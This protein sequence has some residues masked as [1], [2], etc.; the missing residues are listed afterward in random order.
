MT[1]QI[2]SINM[3]IRKQENKRIAILL[4]CLCS[5]LYGYNQKA[6]HVVLISIDGFRPDFY[7]D[8][9][10]SAPNLR[11]MM[12]NGAY[13]KGVR[14]VFPSVTYPAHTTIITGAYPAKHGIYY[15][16]PV[17]SKKGEWYWEES[18]IKV[19]TLWDAVHDAGLRSG[20]VMWPVTVGAP[21][22]YNFPVKRADD[23]GSGNQLEVTLP[24]VKPSTLIDDFQ[25]ETGR[26]TEADFNT[27]NTID[28]TIGNLGA[29]I[30][31]K[32]RPNL[33]AL[34]FVTADHQQHSYGREGPEVQH[35]VALIDSMIGVVIKSIR[36]AGLEKTTNVIITGDH[37]FVNA[38]SN[39]S[40]NVLLEQHKIYKADSKLYFHA[41]GGAA[42]LYAAKGTGKA[43]I[44]Q[45]KNI[46]NALPDEQK[47]VFRILDR[48]QLD[49]IGANPEVVLG[50]A[51]NKGY[52]ATNNAKGEL[53]TRKKTGGA[54]GYYPDFDE[55]NTGFIAYGPAITKKKIIE[56]MGIKDVAPLVARLLGLSFVAPDGSLVPGIIIK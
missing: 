14:S 39:F 15:N 35:A 21:I 13:S 45:V 40:P 24:F 52:V 33:V 50:L 34:H 22:D 12:N 25:T 37:G 49:V 5:F 47:K 16:A 9:K 56:G 11:M 42:F 3:R 29:Y 44:D 20:S 6:D 43:E 51:M 36:D 2:M 54:H 53:I 26:L 30:I 55:I 41:T 32:Y 31:K 23:D 19:P 8:K 18:Y 27:T 17:D 28:I 46:L 1:I 4:I 38:G 7:L 10:W 48:A